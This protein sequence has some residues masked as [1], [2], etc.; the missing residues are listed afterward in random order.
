[1]KF[2]QYRNCSSPGE[3]D[4]KVCNAPVGHIFPDQG[5]FIILLNTKRFQEVGCVQDF[6]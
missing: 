3:K 1:M 2:G 4:G 6:I 5:D